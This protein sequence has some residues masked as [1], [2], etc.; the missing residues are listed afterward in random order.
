LLS[1]RAALMG[2]LLG[3]KP[4]R[5]GGLQKRCVEARETAWRTRGPAEGVK[6]P[7][8]RRTPARWYSAGRGKCLN[9][10]P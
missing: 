3:W 2:G 8:P 7:G 6:K 5:F 9:P 10:G 1:V 4:S